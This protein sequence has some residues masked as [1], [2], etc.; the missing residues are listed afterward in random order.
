MR[1]KGWNEQ[2]SSVGVY[3]DTL[4]FK[5]FKTSVLCSFIILD[6]MEVTLE[7]KHETFFFLVNSTDRRIC[8]ITKWKLQ[9]CFLPHYGIHP[10]KVVSRHAAFF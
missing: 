2:L 3:A 4:I 10:S 6:K 1:R 5:V 9:H 8:L 7:R